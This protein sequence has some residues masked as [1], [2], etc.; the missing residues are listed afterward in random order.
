MSAKSGVSENS[1]GGHRSVVNREGSA[2]DI[3]A[4]LASVDPETESQML[5][6]SIYA[7]SDSHS[8]SLRAPPTQIP[9]RSRSSF[10]FQS[11]SSITPSNIIKSFSRRNLTPQDT[12]MPE[13]YADKFGKSPEMKSQDNAFIKEISGS[14]SAIWNHPISRYFFTV[15]KNYCARKL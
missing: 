15:L 2:R 10:S 13:E 9:I 14:F 7:L 8:D 12:R 5:S 11:A 3:S 6:Q 4:I 1:Y